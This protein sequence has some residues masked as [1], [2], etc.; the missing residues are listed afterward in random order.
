MWRIEQFEVSE[1]DAKFDAMRCALSPGMG[2]RAVRPGR[3]ERLMRG[4]TIVMS[5]TPAELMDLSWFRYKATGAVLINGLGL[6]CAVKMAL[7]KSEV[8][9]VTVIELA[10]PVIDLIGPRF[11]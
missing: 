4:P 8:R 1:Q 7:E 5:D 2:R 11:S 10:Q 9:E 6:G 3:Y